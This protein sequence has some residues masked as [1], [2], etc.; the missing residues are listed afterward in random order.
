M[1][2]MRKINKPIRFFG[3]SSGQFAIFMLFVAITIIV[4]IFKQFHP[5]LI[6]GIISAILFFSAMLFKT[7]KKEH[8]AGNPDYLSGLSIRSAT[9][10]RIT[11]KKRIFKFILNPESP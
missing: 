6:I 1:R 2:T 9:P 11:D 7:L 5:I 4:S 10:R 8:K 3:L